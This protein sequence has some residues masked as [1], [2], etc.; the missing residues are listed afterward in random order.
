[1]SNHPF[2]PTRFALLA[3]ALLSLG[4]AGA[5]AAEPSPEPLTRAQVQAEYLRARAAGELVAPSDFYAHVRTAL[6]EARSIRLAQRSGE[7]QQ[8]VAL[9]P[10]QQASAPR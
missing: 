1:M 3:A 7:A 9:P 8:L 2:A 4:S 6:Q 10:H 5:I